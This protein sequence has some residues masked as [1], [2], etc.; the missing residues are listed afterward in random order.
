MRTL[1]LNIRDWLQLWID[2][3]NNGSTT[4]YDVSGNGRDGTAIAMTQTRI[5]QHKKMSFS[6]SWYINLPTTMASSLWTSFTWSWWIK[7]KETSGTYYIWS[8]YNQ[9]DSPEIRIYISANT[10]NFYLY[11]WWGYQCQ[12]S[13]AYTSTN[14]N[15]ITIIATTNSFIMYIN[16]VAVTSDT[17]WSFNIDWATI[18]SIWYYWINWTTQAQKF[19]W[20]ITNVMIWNR[21]LS[22]T[23]VQ[24]LHKA[25]YIK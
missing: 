14:W 24:Q 10:L 12:L 16:W 8:L 5:L 4:Y 22:A 23:E 3:S 21:A 18:H 7:A 13:T 17:S 19:N 20:D 2:G 11:D 25:Q 15:Y 1:P 9:G 6:W